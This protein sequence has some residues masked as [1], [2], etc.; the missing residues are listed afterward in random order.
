[1]QLSN[2]ISNTYQSKCFLSSRETTKGL[3]VAA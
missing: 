1:M 2:A 3:G